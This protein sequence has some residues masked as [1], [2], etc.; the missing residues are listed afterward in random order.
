MTWLSLSEAAEQTQTP[1]E[2]LNEYLNFTEEET[3]SEQF[4]ALGL[5]FERE[6]YE[7]G[8]EKFLKKIVSQTS[9]EKGVPS[10]SNPEETSN[11]YDFQ[12]GTIKIAILLLKCENNNTERQCIIAASSHQ[13]L[14]IT[15]IVSW[16][17]LQPLPE[18][19]RVILEQLKTELPRRKTTAQLNQSKAKPPSKVQQAAPPPVKNKTEPKPTQLK[20]F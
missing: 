18:P 12:K 9:T 7:S 13:D 4:A 10:P 2:Q 3:T 5:L 11:P 16:K 19:I 8:D 6:R 20:L 17:Q 15:Q 14:P 1:V